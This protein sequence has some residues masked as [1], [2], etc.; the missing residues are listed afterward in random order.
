MK[1]S[2]FDVLFEYAQTVWPTLQVVKQHLLMSWTRF[3]EK[4][5]LGTWPG[6][7]MP[8]VKEKP[9]ADTCLRD[10]LTL[11]RENPELDQDWRIQT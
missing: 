6:S 5:I 2:G 3:A 4:S 9:A 10:T 11:S 8:M 7:V 1:H